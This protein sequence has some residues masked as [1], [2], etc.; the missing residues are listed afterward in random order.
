L[1]LQDF[2]TL[3]M[4]RYS[5]TAIP[6]SNL[7]DIAPLRSLSVDKNDG[8]IFQVSLVPAEIDIICH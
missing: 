8:L 5:S 1:I 2:L 3:E 6:D 7:S 4:R